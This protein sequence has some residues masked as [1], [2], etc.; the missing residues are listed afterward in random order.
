MSETGEEHSFESPLRRERVKECSGTIG[1]DKMMF[2]YAEPI[3]LIR[4]NPEITVWKEVTGHSE[5]PKH[6]AAILTEAD[7]KAI[8]LQIKS[9]QRRNSL[10]RLFG[11][12][13]FCCLDVTQRVSCRRR[14]LLCPTGVGAR[15]SPRGHW[16]WNNAGHSFSRF[17]GDSVADG[18]PVHH[19]AQLS[20]A[21]CYELIW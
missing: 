18:L 3:A 19:L 20:N 6:H 21:S 10:T 5:L 9:N 4:Q 2:Q 1:N 12:D 16:S 17:G 11:F 13:E 7:D 8:L 14:K 15:T